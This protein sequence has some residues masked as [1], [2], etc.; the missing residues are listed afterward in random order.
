MKELTKK[1]NKKKKLELR[2]KELS[3]K[4]E[5][6]SKEVEELENQEIVIV[7]RRNKITLE[8]LMKQI[9]EKQGKEEFN[10]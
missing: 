6:I 8:E 10:E 3:D 9:K 5:I 2:I 4:L 1:R 7:C